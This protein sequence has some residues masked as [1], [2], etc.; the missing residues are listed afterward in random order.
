MGILTIIPIFQEQ[1]HEVSE[2]SGKYLNALYK[3]VL[4]SDTMPQLEI[5]S[6]LLRDFALLLT[7]RAGYHG[8]ARGYL[9]RLA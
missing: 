6:N 4:E 9:V 8:L 3:N 7:R 2:I 5:H 1:R